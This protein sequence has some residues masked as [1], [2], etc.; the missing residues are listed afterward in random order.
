[1]PE[2]SLSLDCLVL[3]FVSNLGVDLTSWGGAGLN[4]VYLKVSPRLESYIRLSL[5]C[6]C[7]FLRLNRLRYSIGLPDSSRFEGIPSDPAF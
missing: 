5:S 6:C 2:V 3:V 7:S 1:M 4:T